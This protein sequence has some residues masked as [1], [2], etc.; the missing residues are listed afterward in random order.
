M[1][2]SI[3][4]CLLCYSCAACSLAATEDVLWMHPFPLQAQ[5][6]A[7]PCRLQRTPACLGPHPSHRGRY[8]LLKLIYGF[9]VCSLH[10]RLQVSP[11]EEIQWGPDPASLRSGHELPLRRLA[12][13]RG[14]H[15]ATLAS[16]RPYA[17]WLRHAESN[18][19]PAAA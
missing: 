19:D 18:A 16:R 6:L 17:L 10:L 8:G 2:R 4:D 7:A 9:R 15:A 3:V 14:G 13:G 12:A 1:I 5:N 11:E